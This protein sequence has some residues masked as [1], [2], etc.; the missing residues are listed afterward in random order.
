MPRQV[1]VRSV[2]NKR[3]Q[4]LHLSS[5]RKKNAYVIRIEDHVRRDRPIAFEKQ[6][7][8]VHAMR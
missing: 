6:H 5:R 1:E 8:S 7:V 3:R 4:S 2:Y